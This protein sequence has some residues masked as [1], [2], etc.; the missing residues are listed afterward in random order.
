MPLDHSNEEFYRAPQQTATRVNRPSLK[1]L[2]QSLNHR[3]M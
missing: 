3:T 1:Q 2:H